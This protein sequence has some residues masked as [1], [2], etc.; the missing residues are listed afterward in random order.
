MKNKHQNCIDIHF[1]VVTKFYRKDIFVTRSHITKSI[2]SQVMF[3]L[4]ITGCFACMIYLG[5]IM[6]IVDICWLTDLYVNIDSLCFIL[7]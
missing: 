5:N 1:Y 4:K 6:D 2:L 3:R 7:L